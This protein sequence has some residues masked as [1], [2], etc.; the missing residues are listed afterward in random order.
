[1]IAVPSLLDSGLFKEG[2]ARVAGSS[3]LVHRGK[4]ELENTNKRFRRFMPGDTDLAAVS[5]RDLIH[6][7]RHLNDQPRKCLG[8][9][10]AAEVFLA[11]LQEEG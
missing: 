11:H 10:T 3:T 7:V 8:Y 5:Q 9:K 6:L 1:M 2:S 4:R